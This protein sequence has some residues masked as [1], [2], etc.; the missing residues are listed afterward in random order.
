MSVVYPSVLVSVCLSLCLSF[1]LFIYGPTG[2]IHTQGGYS[3]PRYRP[4]VSPHINMHALIFEDAL[5][6]R[7]QVHALILEQKNILGKMHALIFEHEIALKKIF[8]QK[9]IKFVN[10]FVL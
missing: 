8:R 10:L 3:P 1:Y 6:F 2:S 4:T 9:K 7:K 5:S